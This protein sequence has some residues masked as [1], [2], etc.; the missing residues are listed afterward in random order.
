MSGYRTIVADP[1]WEVM[2]GRILGS[3]LFNDPDSYRGA[4]SRPLPYPTM[5]V[6]EIAALPVRELAEKDA[7]LYIWTI[8][9]YVEQTYA[10]ARAWGFRPSTLITWAKTPIGGGMGG[11]WGLSTEH[12]LFARRGTCPAIGRITGTWFQWPR[13]EHS[14]KPDA[15]QDHVETVSPGPYLELFARR[16]RLGWDTWGNEALEHVTLE[17]PA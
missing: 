16:Q 15:F 13:G 5:K 14:A 3:A 17:A 7:H 9:A 11:T 1:P 8:N 2:R 6:E 10:I 12:I 4:P